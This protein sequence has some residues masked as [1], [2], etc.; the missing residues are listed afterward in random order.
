[1]PGPDDGNAFWY[2]NPSNF[3]GLGQFSEHSRTVTSSSRTLSQP[4]DKFHQ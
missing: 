1:M 2:G 3:E 4:I